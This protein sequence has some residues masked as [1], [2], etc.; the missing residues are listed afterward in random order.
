MFDTFKKL[1]F[2]RQ[3]SF[4]EGR[5]LLLGRPVMIA[6]VET[7]AFLVKTLRE[8]M[9]QKKADEMIYNAMKKTGIQYM[10]GIKKGFSMSKL[11]MIKWSVNSITLA[12]WGKVTVISADAQKNTFNLRVDDSAVLKELG[13]SSEPTDIIL[14]GY[15]AG[16]GT[17]IFEKDVNVKEVKCRAMGD[18][19]CEFI[20]V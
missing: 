13:K 1:M 3:I 14:A 15:F 19:Y 5:I 2:A 20:T 8:E 7:F 16:G 11:D 12:G 4:E 18:A 10:G 6:P 17:A 9:G